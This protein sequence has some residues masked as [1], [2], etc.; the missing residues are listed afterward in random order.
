MSINLL[1]DNANPLEWEQWH[2]SGLFKGITTNPTLLKEASQHCTISNL[3]DLS[4]KA[5]RLGYKELHIQAWGK[6]ALDLYDCGLSISKLSNQNLRIYVKLPLTLEGSKAAKMLNQSNIPI[7]F[8]ACYKVKQVLIATSLGAHYI[9]PYLGRIN[10][11]G[12]DG[13]KEIKR[14]QKVL[15][16]IRSTCQILVASIRSSNDICDLATVGIK[17]FTISP[18]LAKEIYHCEETLEAIKKFEIDLNNNI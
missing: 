17:T 14:M 12:L 8:T 15:N 2:E 1:L 18:K 16:G 9:A 13:N 7:T 5:E 11:K 3:L 10:D 6:G 4:L